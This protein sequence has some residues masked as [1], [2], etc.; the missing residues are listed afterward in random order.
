MP[1]ITH[2]R[3]DKN[4]VVQAAVDLLNTEGLAALTLSHLAEKLGIRTPSLYNH[5]NGLAGL[6]QDLAIL[7][8]RML[9][10]CLGEAAIGHSGADLFMECAQAFRGYVKEH[11]GLYMS[12]CAH[13]EHS[14]SRTQTSSMKRNVL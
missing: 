4:A 14:K 7:N 1:R 6:Q 13:R 11:P 5:V 8:A 3:L 9:A 2:V 10:D 12:T